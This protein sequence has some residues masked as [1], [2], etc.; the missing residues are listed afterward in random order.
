[1]TVKVAPSHSRAHNNVTPFP[2]RQSALQQYGVKYNSMSE[3]EA[4]FSYAWMRF[5]ERVEPVYLPFMLRQPQKCDFHNKTMVSHLLDHTVVAYLTCHDHWGPDD[6]YI[7]CK[8]REQQCGQQPQVVPS[9]WGG[10]FGRR[11]SGTE[12]GYDNQ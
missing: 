1:M 7:N 9:Q 10:V 8:G 2:C 11:Q 4:Y 3:Y 12:G 5:R 6:Y